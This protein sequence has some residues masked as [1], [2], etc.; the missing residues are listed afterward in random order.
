MRMAVTHVQNMKDEPF[1]YSFDEVLP[2]AIEMV[3]VEEEDGGLAMWYKYDPEM[4][5][6]KYRFFFVANAEPLEDS[7]IFVAHTLN[8]NLLFRSMYLPE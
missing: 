2:D 3:A 4:Q 7:A 6:R 1:G 5:G 8:G